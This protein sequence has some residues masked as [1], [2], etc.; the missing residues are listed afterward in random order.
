MV[1]EV[2]ERGKV[3]ERERK[4]ANEESK[5]EPGEGRRRNET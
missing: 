4:W 2:E 5:E 1:G 3:G